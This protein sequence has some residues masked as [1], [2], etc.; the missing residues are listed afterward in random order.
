MAAPAGPVDPKRTPPR[1]AT[2]SGAARSSWPALDG[3]EHAPGAPKGAETPIADRAG[4]AATVVVV[5]VSGRVPVAIRRTHIPRFVVPRAAPQHA[6]GLGASQASGPARRRGRVA[7]KTV[8]SEIK[9]SAAKQ[10]APQAPGI[11]MPRMGHPA[12][13]A[14]TRLLRCRGPGPHA[15]TQPSEPVPDKRDHPHSLRVGPAQSNSWTPPRAVPSPA[16]RPSRSPC[17]A[18]APVSPRSSR[19]AAPS[20]S[21]PSSD[22][23]STGARSRSRPSSSAPSNSHFVRL[24][25]QVPHQNLLRPAERAIAAKFTRLLSRPAPCAIAR[26]PTTSCRKRTVRDQRRHGSG[27]LLQRPE[28]SDTGRSAAEFRHQAAAQSSAEN[29]RENSPGGYRPPVPHK[30]QR[31]KDSRLNPMS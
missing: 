19:P 18:L 16:T 29:P 5:A 23:P 14:L 25:A 21:A 11:R 31:D 24:P 8:C 28:G 22:A 10:R 12:G 17:P 27:A 30:G 13:N 9:G 20:G 7:R 2:P 3:P 4:D 15:V 26:E 1:G 6:G